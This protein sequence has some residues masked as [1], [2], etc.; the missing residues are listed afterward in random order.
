VDGSGAFTQLGDM[1]NLA[2]IL[3]LTKLLNQPLGRLS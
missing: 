3:K 1:V 2:H